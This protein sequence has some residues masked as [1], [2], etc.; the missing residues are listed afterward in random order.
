[1]YL[2]EPEVG[3]T[4]EGVCISHA[5]TGS[6]YPSRRYPCLI[7][8]LQ[9]RSLRTPKGSKIVISITSPIL[10]VETTVEVCI[11]LYGPNIVMKT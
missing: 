11:C 10:R 7:S 8:V 5:R 6:G 1:M 4:P 3:V 9:V 2:A